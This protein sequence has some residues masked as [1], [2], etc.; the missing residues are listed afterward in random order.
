MHKLNDINIFQEPKKNDT[1]QVTKDKS[2][3][4]KIKKIKSDTYRDTP[5][6]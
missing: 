5:G 4:E 1:K 3:K 6:N 2:P